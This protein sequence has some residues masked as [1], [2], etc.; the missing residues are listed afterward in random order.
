VRLSAP[1]P[2][3]LA[4]VLGVE[5]ASPAQSPPSP[6][7][8][9]LAPGDTV[10]A[11]DAERIDG[12]FQ[13]VGFDGGSS[14]V[15][16][17]FLSSCPTCHKMLPEW[18]RAYGRRPEGLTVIGVVLDREPPG[19]FQLMPVAFPVVRSPGRALLDTYRVHRVPLTLRVGPGG[20]V[21]EVA[22]GLV[23]PIRLGQIFRK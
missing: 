6:E 3:L 22:Q 21:E 16:L 23:D 17:F 14:T 4:A 18:S 9:Y 15:L 7:P 2:I 20:K 5:P 19:F 10:P 11:F 8:R 13:H 1:V 12:T